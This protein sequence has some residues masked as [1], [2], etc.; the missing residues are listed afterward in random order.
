MLDR[1]SEISGKVG[2]RTRTTIPALYGRIL[3][4]TW[5]QTRQA[6][7]ARALLLRLGR[8][9]SL[10]GP[11][12]NPSQTS[13]MDSLAE[14]PFKDYLMIRYHKSAPCIV[15]HPVTRFALQSPVRVVFH[16]S[17]SS[18]A[19]DVLRRI[20]SNVLLD[21]TF[22]DTGRKTWSCRFCPTSGRSTSVVTPTDER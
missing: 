6:R 13:C 20:S 12:L 1:E 18:G 4:C 8:P 2:A 19:K 14:C 5:Q 22:Q 3:S 15:R 17:K 21:E 16:C 9:S 10:F 7:R 11:A